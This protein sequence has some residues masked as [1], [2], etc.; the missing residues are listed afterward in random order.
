MATSD[1]RDFVMW[2]ETGDDTLA[3]RRPDK[4]SRIKAHVAAFARWERREEEEGPTFL[5]T[6]TILI[7]STQPLPRRTQ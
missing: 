3:G 6:A 2:R 4:A 5:N 7:C 1:S